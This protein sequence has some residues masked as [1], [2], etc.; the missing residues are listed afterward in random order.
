MY[1]LR[2]N[3]CMQS[4]LLSSQRNAHLPDEAA[5]WHGHVSIVHDFFTSEVTGPQPKYKL[6]RYTCSLH[7]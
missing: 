2:C 5:G 1:R 3:G 7:Q 4:E 6:E